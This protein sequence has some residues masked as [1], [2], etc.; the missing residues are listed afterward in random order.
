VTNKLALVV[1]VILG[2]MSIVLIKL[3]V[4]R[5]KGEAEA[6]TQQ[7][8]VLIAAR[9][10]KQGE[11]LEAKDVDRLKLPRPA[12][13]AFKKSNIENPDA[14]TG[15]RATQDIKMGQV[16][17]TYH[18]SAPGRRS[19]PIQIER[20]MRAVSIAV[21]PVTGVGG[22]IRPGDFVDVVTFMEIKPDTGGQQ[23]HVARTLVKRALVLAC[24]SFTD[25]HAERPLTDYQTVT[26]QLKPAD[27]NKVILVQGRGMYVQLVRMDDKAVEAPTWDAYTPDMLYK[28]IEDEIKKPR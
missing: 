10:I 8:E 24:D 7:A 19:A 15:A 20:E 9:D 18:F 22:L 23:V 14:V 21:T 25:P 28:E 16:L 3:Y 13:D 26:L 5:I 2:V 1:A 6:K 17:Q 27:V 12:I 11:T 4:D